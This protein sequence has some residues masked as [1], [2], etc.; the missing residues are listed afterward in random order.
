M[1]IIRFPQRRNPAEL[2]QILDRRIREDAAWAE[3]RLAIVRYQ[4]NPTAAR[5]CEA[6]DARRAWKSMW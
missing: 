2:I 5:H 1:D 6:H 3:F 4:R